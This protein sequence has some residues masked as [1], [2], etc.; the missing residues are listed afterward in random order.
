MNFLIVHVYTPQVMLAIPMV[1]NSSVWVL[2]L[3]RRPPNLVRIH[4]ITCFGV[5]LKYKHRNCFFNSGT[6]VCIVQIY[7]GLLYGHLSAFV[8]ACLEHF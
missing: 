2:M 8:S 7:I 4:I 1:P 3:Q 6:V 5:M